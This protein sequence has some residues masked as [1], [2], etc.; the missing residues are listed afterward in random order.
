MGKKG[1]VVSTQQLS[2]EFHDGFCACEETLRVEE[3]VVGLEMGV[4]AV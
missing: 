3:T 4:D 2:D 1:T